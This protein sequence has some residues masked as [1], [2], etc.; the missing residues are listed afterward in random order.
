MLQS[1]HTFLNLILVVHYTFF[2]RGSFDPSVQSDNDLTIVDQIIVLAP[3]SGLI[4]TLS[5]VSR[6]YSVN[7]YSVKLL[8]L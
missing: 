1:A 6:A 8:P 2:L 5:G 7:L 4:E 3:R